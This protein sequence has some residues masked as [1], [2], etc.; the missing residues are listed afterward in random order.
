MKRNLRIEEVGDRLFL[1]EREALK[2]Q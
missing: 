2:G 1:R